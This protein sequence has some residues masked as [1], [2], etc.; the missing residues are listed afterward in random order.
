MVKTIDGQLYAFNAT[1]GKK[2]WVSH[3]GAP[4]FILKA[5]SSPVVVDNVVLVGHSDGKLDA[6]DLESGN[7]LWQR[8][9]AYASGSSDVER[10]VD[11]DSTPVVRNGIA[12]IAT[13]QGFVG[14]F[15]LKTG[16]FVWRKPASTYKDIVIDSKTLYL[17]DSDDVVWAY[18]LENGKVRWKQDKLKARSLTKPVLINNKLALGDATGALHLL[19]TQSGEFLSRKQFNAPIYSSPTAHNNELYVLTSDG[20]LN[21]LTVG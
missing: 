18:N 7:L 8:G 2:D 16:Q 19:S 9:I 12:Y 13:Y 11:I 1:N 17:A 3:H 15:S 20:R 6:V 10:L 5:S 14:A 21:E 4:N